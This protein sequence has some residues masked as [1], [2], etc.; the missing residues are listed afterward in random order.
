MFVSNS[1]APHTFAFN[2]DEVALA[3][4]RQLKQIEKEYTDKKNRFDLIDKMMKGF[5]FVNGRDDDGNNKIGRPLPDVVKKTPYNKEPTLVTNRV[6]TSSVDPAIQKEYA[7]LGSDVY[8]LKW[9]IDSLTKSAATY[10]TQGKRHYEFSTDQVIFM[11]L[12]KI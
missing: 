9:K 1:T 5:G 8:S 10:G 7:Q 12:D 2:G 4:N 3:C 6:D 11:G